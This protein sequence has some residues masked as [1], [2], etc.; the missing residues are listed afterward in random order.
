MRTKV[1]SELVRSEDELPPHL[2]TETEAGVV[3]HRC[4]HV[5]WNFKLRE[6]GFT[7]RLHGCECAS[8]SDLGSHGVAVLRTSWVVSVAR[9]GLLDDERAVTGE[10]AGA[11]GA[12]GGVV[13]LARARVT[14]PR[15][16]AAAAAV[17]TAGCLRHHQEGPR[18]PPRP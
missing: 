9:S 11:G 16:D 6:Y 14:P 8:Q 7:Q 18:A 4:V 10:D 3:V 15:E 13:P 12:A 5:G 17:E 2:L 1:A